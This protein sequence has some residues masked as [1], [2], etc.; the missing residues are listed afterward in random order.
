MVLLRAALKTR[1]AL[2]QELRQKFLD[3]V[4][5]DDPHAAMYETDFASAQDALCK[6]EVNLRRKEEALGVDE[7]QELEE[8]A[9]SEYMRV[10]MNA[11]ALKLRLRDRLRARKFEMDPVER[12]Y[13]RL[14]NGK[15]LFVLRRLQTDK[16]HRC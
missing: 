14:L 3:G 4:E 13:R 15:L 11:R 2:V 7:H 1:R 9:N 16:V 8:L 12:T 5:N 10:R 6:A